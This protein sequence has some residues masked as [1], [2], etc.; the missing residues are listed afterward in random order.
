MTRNR[1]RIIKNIEQ[2]AAE[3]AEARR[4]AEEKRLDISR[5][6]RAAAAKSHEARRKALKT[7]AE[8]VGVAAPSCEFV[9]SSLAMS[10]V[11]IRQLLHLAVAAID[12]SVVLMEAALASRLSPPRAFESRVNAAAY[13]LSDLASDIEEILT[14][15]RASKPNPEGTPPS[16][17]DTAWATAVLRDKQS[18]G[19]IDALR[20]ALLALESAAAKK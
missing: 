18:T 12:E 15:I 13:D 11:T 6:R 10:G 2:F 1:R 4:L 19:F 17:V 3:A 16:I 14:A 7:A 8:P 20:A 5:K 9:N